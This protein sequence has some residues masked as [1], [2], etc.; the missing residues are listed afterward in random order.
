MD[1]SLKNKEFYS[2]LFNKFDRAIISNLDHFRKQINVSI[3][4]A[5]KRLKTCEYT[6]FQYLDKT[7]KAYSNDLNLAEVLVNKELRSKIIMSQW[8]NKFLSS[9]TEDV[10]DPITFSLS[11]FSLNI[12]LSFNEVTPMYLIE[13]N[14]HKHLIDYIALK[15]ELVIGPAL[16]ALVHIS[17][18]PELKSPII[19]CG[20]LTTVLK[21]LVHHDSKLILAQATKLCASLSLDFPSKIPMSQSG[22]MHALFDLILGAHQD[23]DRHIQYNTLCAIVNVTYKNDANRMLS[24]ELN[25]IKPLLTIMKT[26]SHE[27]LIIQSIKALANI[28]FGNG[29]TA[30]CNI[31]IINIK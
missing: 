13:T 23:V 30:N 10:L 6:I 8:T 7:K 14:I 3:Q 11:R 16:M 26:T 12:S 24:V 31:C 5:E 18:Y 28:S 19:T 27:D 4:K 20:A 22:C 2:K 15:S 21:L 9:T 25:G 17:L 29:Y 1:N